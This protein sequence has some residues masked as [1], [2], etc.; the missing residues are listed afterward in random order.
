MIIPRCEI[1][2][3]CLFTITA[4]KQFRGNACCSSN[5]PGPIRKSPWHQGHWFGEIGVEVNLLQYIT[6]MAQAMLSNCGY[7]LVL[8]QIEI[9]QEIEDV[10]VLVCE[11]CRSSEN[12]DIYDSEK[13][14]TPFICNSCHAMDVM[15]AY[16]NEFKMSSNTTTTTTQTRSVYYLHFVHPENVVSSRIV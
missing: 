2:T 13:N 3:C 5:K 11:Y 10:C 9:K 8:N 12:V 15:E 1:I 16:Q 7:K 14:T 4:F 6:T